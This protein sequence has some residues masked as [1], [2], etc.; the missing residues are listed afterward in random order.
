MSED[1]WTGASPSGPDP[2]WVGML[3]VVVG[4]ILFTVSTV[5]AFYLRGVFW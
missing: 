2:R 1:P 4:L 5:V 3:I